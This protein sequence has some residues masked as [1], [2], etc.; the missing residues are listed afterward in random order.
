MSARS[1]AVSDGKKTHFGRAGEFYAMSELLLRGWN[2]AVPVVDVGDDVLVIDDNDKTT[3]RLQVKSSQTTGTPKTAKF[4]LS[5][6]QLRSAQ[7]IEL[8]FML[9][10]RDD[11]R[12][13]FLVLPRAELLAIRDRYVAGHA[14]RK[15]RGRAPRKDTDAKTDALALGIVLTETAGEWRATGWD[16]DL[17]GYLDR[18]PAALAPVVAG[19]GSSRVP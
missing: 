12:W 9:L 5:R 16:E 11:E 15:R 19:P 3:Y 6:A 17:G 2:V 1:A 8:F 10:V 18:W 4:N 13:H 14:S 7:P